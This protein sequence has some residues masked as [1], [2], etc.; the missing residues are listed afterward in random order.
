MLHI[1]FKYPDWWQWV[2]SMT[3]RKSNLLLLLHL[4]LMLFRCNASK[5]ISLTL[6]VI[7]FNWEILL[8]IQVVRMEYHWL[9]CLGVSF[10]IW[11]AESILINLLFYWR[12]T[13][14]IWV[15]IIV[16]QFILRSWKMH[17]GRK[18]M[19]RKLKWVN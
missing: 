6:A 5:C 17:M 14:F 7:T 1:L 8:N 16:N 9:L 3:I 11:S 18:L 13:A 2:I 4:K 15:I 12:D 19:M 10:V